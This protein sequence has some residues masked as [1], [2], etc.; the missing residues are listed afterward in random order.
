MIAAW[1]WPVPQPMLSTRTKKASSMK[2]R[3][4]QEGNVCFLTSTSVSS[5]STSRKQSHHFSFSKLL[6]K[7]PISQDSPRDFLSETS[8]CFVFVYFQN[9]VRRELLLLQTLSNRPLRHWLVSTMRSRARRSSHQWKSSRY[10]SYPFEASPQY[11]DPVEARNWTFRLGLNGWKTRTMSMKEMRI[12]NIHDFS[13]N[14]EET[15]RLSKK[16]R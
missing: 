7:F 9:D 8:G 15:T 13:K 11:L 1:W 16:C 5:S 3:A 4:G 6:L 10:P 12:A 14:K 2:L